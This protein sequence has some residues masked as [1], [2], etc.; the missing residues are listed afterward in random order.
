MNVELILVL[1][2]LTTMRLLASSRLGASIRTVALQGILLG[3]L[4][5]L[6]DGHAQTWRATSLA[7]GS[8]ALK[9]FVFP[10]LLF[11][12]MRQAEISREME[13]YVGLVA[14][15]LAGVLALAGAFGLSAQLPGLPATASP[16][17]VPVA[18][19]AILAGLFFIVTRRLAVS[20]VLGFIVLENGVFAFGVGVM[21]N[22]SLLVEAGVLLDVFVAVFVMGI[23]LFHINR[24]FEHLD[25]DRLNQLK[26]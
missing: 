16:L 14:S 9:G 26:D 11:R 24:E 6:V 13:P 22:T 4:P 10:W 23:T 19:F 18:L 3:A 12:A 21:Q 1:V 25:T 17:L 15:V 8:I 5:L 7:V 20:Q 2:V